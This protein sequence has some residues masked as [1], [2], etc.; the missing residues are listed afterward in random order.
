MKKL[1][2]KLL[3]AVKAKKAIMIYDE[4]W[5][6]QENIRCLIHL[7]DHDCLAEKTLNFL[8]NNITAR[9]MP[10]ATV[11]LKL[12]DEKL[13]LGQVHDLINN[14]AIGWIAT[15]VTRFENENNPKWTEY[16]SEIKDNQNYVRIHYNL[17]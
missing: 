7:K 6:G 4:Q 14:K 9:K 8:Q 12:D 15:T 2:D 13:K 3:D 17:P 10:K 16:L 11:Y 5:E 1:I